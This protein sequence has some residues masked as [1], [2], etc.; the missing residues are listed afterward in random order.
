MDGRVNLSL[1]V[2]S[3][4]KHLAQG[5]GKIGRGREETWS[6]EVGWDL[7]EFYFLSNVCVFWGILI[8]FDSTQSRDHGTQVHIQALPHYWKKWGLKVRGRTGEKVQ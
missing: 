1:F 2:E 6:Q 5:K 4:N 3:Y 7:V 8:E